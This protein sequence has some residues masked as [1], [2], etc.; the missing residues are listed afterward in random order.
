[1]VILSPNPE[2]GVALFVF[3]GNGKGC[4]MVCKIIRAGSRNEFFTLVLLVILLLV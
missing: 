3:P 1:M 2:I 4:N